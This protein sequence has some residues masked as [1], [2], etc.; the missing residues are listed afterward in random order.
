MDSYQSPP[1]GVFEL[2]V[3]HPEQGGVVETGRP[4][5]LEL[6]RLEVVPLRQLFS[7]LFGELPFPQHSREKVLQ[8]TGEKG[9]C[10]LLLI[11]P[12]LV[13]KVRCQWVDC[14]SRC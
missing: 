12:S 14:L 5:L 13:G 9:Q 2:F 7:A 4:Y 6:F 11:D 1:S 10:G 3:T 8:G